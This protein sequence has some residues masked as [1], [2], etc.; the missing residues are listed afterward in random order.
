MDYLVLDCETTVFAKGNPYSIQNK[1]CL[2]GLKPPEQRHH[3]EIHIKNLEYSDHSYKNNLEILQ[4]L[5][6]ETKLLVLFNA[7][8]DLAWLR[9][10]SIDFSHCRVWDCQLV[11]FILSAQGHTMPSLNEVATYHNI[12]GKLDKVKEL[13]DN[14]LDTTEIPLDIL[15]EYLIQDLT[16]TEQVYLLQKEIV[17]KQSVQMQNLISLSNQD[18]LVLLEMEWN[19]I[20]MDFLGMKQASIII[21]QQINTI[22][23]G[24]NDYFL[25]CGIPSYCLNYNSNDCLSAI[26]YG[27]TIQEVIRLLNG[28]YQSGEKKGLPRFKLEVIEHVLPRRVEPPR[29]SELKKAGF[30]S[31][32][33]ETLRNIKARKEDRL[34]LDKIL[35]LSK[36]EKLNGTYYEGLAKLHLERDQE[37]NYLHGQFN[38]C[39]ARTGRLSSSSPNLQNLPPEMDNYIVTRF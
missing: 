30:F 10:Y 29:G 21:K 35:E 4:E 18:L 9:R 16:I 20:K 36:L 24:L 32:N 7:K 3:P 33:E 11:H 22:E 23:K 17:Q 37:D 34:L 15:T 25:G 6:Y 28:E 19:G 31:T 38:Q 5:I 8:F 27:G 1:L 12:P 39:I 13:W 26:L 2:V 14:G